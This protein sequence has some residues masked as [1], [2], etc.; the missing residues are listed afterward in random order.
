MEFSSIRRNCLEQ[1]KQLYIQGTL[2]D[3][4]ENITEKAEIK[5]SF[6]LPAK[7]Q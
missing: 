5:K 4:K 7:P 3:A 2:Q 6:Y 1:I